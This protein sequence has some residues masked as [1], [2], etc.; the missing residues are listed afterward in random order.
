MIYVE[1][2]YVA[3]DDPLPRFEGAVSE[4]ILVFTPAGVFTVVPSSNPRNLVEPWQVPFLR[5]EEVIEVRS[6]YVLKPFLVK[7]KKRKFLIFRKTYR[8]LFLPL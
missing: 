1:P 7:L 8:V 6:R 4:S 3:P 2:Y 5:R